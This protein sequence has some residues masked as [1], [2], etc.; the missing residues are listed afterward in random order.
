MTINDQ[1][2]QLNRLYENALSILNGFHSANFSD[3]SFVEVE[4]NNGNGSTALADMLQV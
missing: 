1:I 4:L 2:K 3:V